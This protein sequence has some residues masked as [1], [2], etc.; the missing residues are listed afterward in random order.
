MQGKVIRKSVPNFPIQRL[1]ND[2][3][4]LNDEIIINSGEDQIKNNR[5]EKSHAFF[6]FMVHSSNLIVPSALGIFPIIDVNDIFL[7][8]FSFTT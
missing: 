1:K 7:S 2:D 5:S 3:A 6:F 8:P 4:P